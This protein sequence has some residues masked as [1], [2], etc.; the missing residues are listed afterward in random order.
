MSDA[1]TARGETSSAKTTV[2]AGRAPD[3]PPNR[4][5][6]GLDRTA[7]DIGMNAG[8]MLL[9]LALSL[10]AAVLLVFLLSEDPAKTL[11]LFFLGPL[12]NAY[13]FGN[14]L[15]G[16]VPLILGGLGVSIAMRSGNLNLG[17]EGQIYSGALAAAVTALALEGAG[18]AGALI[19]LIAGAFFAGLAAAFSGLCKVRWNTNELITTFLVS[20]TLILITNYCVTGPFLD[21]ATSLQAT[22]KIPE[23]F[24]LPLILSPSNLSAAVFFALLAVV[25]VWVFLYRTRPGYEIRMSGLNLMFAR[26]G[27]INTD[28]SIVVSMFLSGAL[29]GAAGGLAVYGTYFSVV[30]E[31]SQGLGWNSLAVALIARSKPAP[32]VPAA[33]FFAWIGSGARLAM[34]FSDVTMEIASVVQSVVFFLVSCAALKNF[35][36]G[37]GKL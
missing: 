11:S 34:Q 14:M 19:A 23:Q 36:S 32:V 33:L 15:N 22:R 13:Y 29:H 6:Q 37:R 16:A 7:A 4:F 12:R 17:G 18:Y 3:S 31:F 25:L 9:I 30:K 21:P 27:G 8:G 28:F 2:G 35:F 1:G 5:G 26:Y 10:L 24:H 20:N